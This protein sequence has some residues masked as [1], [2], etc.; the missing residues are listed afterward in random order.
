MG[1]GGIVMKSDST[2]RVLDAVTE[3]HNAERAV[4]RESLAAH[5]GLPLSI[6]D[7][8]IGVLIDDGHVTRERRGLFLPVVEYEPARIMSKTLFPDGTVKI[9]IGDE[10]MTL[11]PKEARMLGEITSGEAQQMYVTD[12]RTRLELFEYQA[13]KEMARL[14]KHI[15]R[16]EGKLPEEPELF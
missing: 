6:V 3:L 5:T 1:N 14:M 4:T 10:V 15:R 12:L 8:R 11:T 7:D 2:Q 9:E 16:L 13:K